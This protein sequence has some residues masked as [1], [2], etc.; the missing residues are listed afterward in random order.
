MLVGPSGVVAPD[1]QSLESVTPPA[2]GSN[3][4]AVAWCDAAPLVPKAELASLL[5]ALPSTA[6]PGDVAVVAALW[7][8][9]G[10]DGVAWPSVDT[11]AARS[12]TS[13]ATVKR[14]LARLASAGLV[15]RHA[16]GHRESNTYALPTPAGRALGPSRR[17]P[18]ARR[19]DPHPPQAPE[20]PGLAPAAV[21]QAQG[22]PLAAQG[23]PRGGLRVSPQGSQGEQT[24]E[25]ARAE[26]QAQAHAPDPPSSP[27]P[28]RAPELRGTANL[29]RR[30]TP[31]QTPAAP[32]APR[33]LA[34]P[35]RAATPP[36]SRPPTRAERSAA[37]RAAWWARAGH[38]VAP[39]VAPPA[40]VA[41]MDR[42][43]PST[44]AADPQGALAVLTAWRGTRRPPE[45]TEA[46]PQG[47]LPLGALATP[48]RAGQGP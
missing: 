41:A 37:N 42:R 33:P 27:T 15:S 12:H 40:R 35:A 25:S 38:T 32:R 44:P 26:A 48:L 29:E 8:F 21:P 11:L 45:A 39:L 24:K 7:T 10:R 20:L 6:G 47:S 23:E 17:P 31:P 14:V 19:P 3:R 9:T 36:S 2:P 46:D 43:E 30:P 4:S 28:S 18:R 13:R 34:P 16:A 5:A 22:E 1:L